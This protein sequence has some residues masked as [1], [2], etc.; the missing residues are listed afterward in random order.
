MKSSQEWHVG[1][2]SVPPLQRGTMRCPRVGTCR[3][4]KTHDS[5]INLR[6]KH[7]EPVPNRKWR[8]KWESYPR[9]VEP[10]APNA[11]GV[12]S[13]MR[14]FFQSWRRER[15]SHSRWGEPHLLS[16]QAPRLSG[17]PPKQI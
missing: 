16:G 6:R 10:A 14:D 17:L 15:D 5:A 12:S 11:F 1:T 3:L 4:Q 9:Q 13:S 8:K 7:S 2:I